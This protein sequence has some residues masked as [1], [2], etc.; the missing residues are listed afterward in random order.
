MKD[1]DFPIKRG[2]TSP[3]LEV[4]L[5]NDGDPIDLSGDV[6][7]GFR[8]RHQQDE[9]LVTG[10]CTIENAVDGE[11]VY[12]WN[13]GDTDTAG[14]YDAEFMLD[15]DMPENMSEFDADETFPSDRYLRI[16]VVESLE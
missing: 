12:I 15:Y 1:P 13:D 5:R 9:T 8:M 4:Q 2:D 6:T 14:R 16:D 10:L 3:P 11:I 7:A